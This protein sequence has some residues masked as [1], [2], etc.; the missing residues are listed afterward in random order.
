MRTIA[1]DMDG[2]LAD[3]YQQFIDMHFTESGT[4]LQRRDMVGLP[5]AKAFPHLLKHVN[6]K[7]FFETAPLIPGGH[8]VVKELSTHY[9]I[10]I[11][12]AATE[13]PLSLTEKHTWLNKYFPFISWQQMVFCG[14][15]EI[16]KT[17]IMID[18]HFK[19]LDGF[20]GKT[21]L[22]TQPHNEKSSPG[23]HERVNNWDEI[24]K[25]LLG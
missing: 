4:I 15:K 6:T 13:F 14:S 24:R 2:V 3:V 19:N 12:S 11:V 5:E 23:K 22:F 8:Q 18:D 21:F 10:F 25:I 20:D 17:D 16:I 7:G 9:K 1:I